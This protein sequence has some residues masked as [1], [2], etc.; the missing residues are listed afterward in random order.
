MVTLVAPLGGLG[1][2]GGVGGW[3]GSCSVVNHQRGPGVVAPWLS[4]ATI[5]Q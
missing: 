2:V 4:Q 3:L 5:L 1:L